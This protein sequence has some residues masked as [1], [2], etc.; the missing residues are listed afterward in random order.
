MYVSV[1]TL[2]EDTKI[3]E[4]F[5][6]GVNKKHSGFSKIAHKECLYLSGRWL[7]THTLINILF[8]VLVI[9][10]VGVAR[11][12]IRMFVFV[13]TLA[14]DTQHNEYCVC[15]VNTGH[16]KRSRCNCGNNSCGNSSCGINSS[17]KISSGLISNGIIS[18][19]INSNGI[20]SNGLAATELSLAGLTAAE[21]QAAELPASMYQLRSWQLRN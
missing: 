4:Y 9:T 14:E 1:G 7:R 19:G 20:I 10:I 21:L 16:S 3:V 8:V 6:C 2:V 12:P 11:S 18:N 17:G 5:L 15:G 13:G